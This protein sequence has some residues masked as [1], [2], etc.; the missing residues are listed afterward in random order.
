MSQLIAPKPHSVMTLVRLV[1]NSSERF[2]GISMHDLL[3][4]GPDVLN[5]ICAVLLRF[6]GGTQAALGDIKKMQN[7]VWLK[8]I[9]VHLHHFLWCGSEDQEIGEYVITRVNTDK[10]AGCIAQLAMREMANLP[11][12]T[13]F[14]E[15]QQVLQ[16]ASYVDNILTSHNDPDRLKTITANIECILKAGVFVLKPWVLSWAKWE[17]RV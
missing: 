3:M 7:S 2:R 16:N 12:F 10:P 14:K 17:K 8:E 15:E 4:K 13:H 1:W 11:S 5:Q 9:E 6:R